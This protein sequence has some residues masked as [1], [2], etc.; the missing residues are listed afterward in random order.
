MEKRAGFL[1][2]MNFQV[3]EIMNEQIKYYSKENW[4]TVTFTILS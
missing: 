1:F 4:G 2:S 3:K